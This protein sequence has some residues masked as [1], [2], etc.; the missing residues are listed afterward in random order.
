MRRTLVLLAPA[1]LL[2]QVPAPQPTFNASERF[3]LE[4][5]AVEK[6]LSEFQ[7]PEALA[8]AETILPPEGSI[9]AFDKERAGGTYSSYATYYAIGRLYFVAGRAAQYSGQWEKA[10][11]FFTKARD[12]SKQNADATKE[13]FTK[14]LEG[15]N[16]DSLLKRGQL[17]G[18]AD[19]I[20]ELK[21]KEAK[22]TLNDEEKQ[23][24]EL[25]KGLESGLANNLKWADNFKKAMDHAAAEAKSMESYPDDLKK[26][27][28]QQIE[29]LDKYKFKN[30]K[31]K[32]I[33]GYMASKPYID[34]LR[35]LDKGNALANLYRFKVLSPE[36]KK[37][38]AEID[39]LLGKAPEPVKGKR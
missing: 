16:Y 3:R 2:A 1:V 19:V 39:R 34:Q 5:P 25:V 20:K 13:A 14:H 6:L 33:E 36:N 12:I 7:Y 26:Q 22:G 32:F 10:F 35:A 18:N 28:D 27:I 29:D 17:E 38:Q 23:Q 15:L 9:P 24:I 4:Y 30:D 21:E 11:E 31:V 37:V 8:K